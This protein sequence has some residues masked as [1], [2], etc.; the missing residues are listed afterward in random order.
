MKN[1]E[2][3]KEKK[4]IKNQQET[5]EK[6]IAK[7]G[8]E[9]LEALKHNNILKKE[10]NNM[11]QTTIN[12]GPYTFEFNTG[13]FSFSFLDKDGNK[14]EFKFDIRSNFYMSRARRIIKTEQGSQIQDISN[15]EAQ[16]LINDVLSNIR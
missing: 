13:Y 8:Q 5:Q 3:E 12:S 16:S 10:V 14:N 7:Q 9:L 15:F 1:I 11:S 2:Q 4:E 6:Q